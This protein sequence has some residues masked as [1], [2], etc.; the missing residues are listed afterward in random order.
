MAT[1]FALRTISKA[2]VTGIRGTLVQGVGFY[3]DGR[4][5]YAVADRSVFELRVVRRVGNTSFTNA[6][7]ALPA[8][9]RVV[10]N[11]NYF[12]GT[13]GLYAR[14][15][16][17]VIDS[18]DVGSVGDVYQ[19][20][21]LAEADAP[22]AENPA[23][24][25]YFGSIGPAPLRYECGPGNAP[26]TIRDGM[27]G[28]G[29]LILRNPTTGKPLRYGI[30]NRYATNPKKTTIP[31]SAA[32]WRDCIQRNNDTYRSIQGETSSG[33]GVC[34]VAVND[35]ENILLLLIKPHG[36]VGD[37][38]TIRD[39]LFEA[40]FDGA[41]FTDGSNSAC[42]AVDRVFEFAPAGYK[43]NLIEY[44]FSLF[45]LEKDVHLRVDFLVLTVLS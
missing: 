20:G 37:L 45:R 36:D 14:A 21:V 31:S 9:F 3:V 22:D 8:G 5:R 34:V 39:K 28:L 24:F 35:T 41:C 4:Y 32:E 18:K 43:D 15:A 29:P 2:N 33:A 27:G 7:T 44:G 23:N 26:G 17:G 16:I 6:V 38:D 25:F 19:G 30:G 1:T 10:T 11:G 40:G 13:R 42:M 12:A